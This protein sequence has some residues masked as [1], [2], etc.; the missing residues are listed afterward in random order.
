MLEKIKNLFSK[1]NAEENEEKDA[2]AEVRNWYS[3]RY[4]TIVVQRNLLFLVT[5]FSLV[6]VFISVFAVERVTSSKSIEPFVV[7]IEKKTGITNVVD[8]ITRSEMFADDALTKYFL[9]KYVN[10][11]ETYDSTTSKFNY[12]KVRLMS[13]RT[14]YS[15]FRKFIKGPDSPEATYG[16]QTKTEMKVRS[17]QIVRPGVA[18]VRFSIIKSGQKS[19]VNH[20]IAYI[21]YGFYVIEMP[22]E[23]RYINPIGFQVH[24]YRVDEETVT[25]TEQ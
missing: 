6:G 7:E 23:E 13:G 10:A 16:A 11:R 25:I 1:N 15:E 9:V 3:D 12:N 17:A 19:G 21:E 14:V 5:L 2:I 4:Q 20:Y 18:Q 22:Q 24:S 8:P